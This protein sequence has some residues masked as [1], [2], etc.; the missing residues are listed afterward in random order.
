MAEY[1][2]RE[3]AEKAIAVLMRRMSTPDG[4]GCGDEYI[5]SAQEAVSYT[6]LNTQ[7][8]LFGKTSQEHS[9]ATKARTSASSSK[10]LSKSSNRP[11]RCLR[12][13]K[14]DG[15]MQTVIWVQDGRLLTDFSTRNTG[16]CPSVAVESTL[17]QILEANAPQKYYLSAKACEG[18]LRRAERRG[19][20]LPQMLKEALMQ[21]IERYTTNQAAGIGCLDSDA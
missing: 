6:H 16:E 1:I 7:V 21:M 10:N 5:L 2:E 14:V 13:L 18:I 8:S 17:S 3:A 19:K 15:P 4:T 20:E 9:A 12:C 11:A